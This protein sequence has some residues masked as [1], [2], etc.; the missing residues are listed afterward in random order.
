MQR[1]AAAAAA[2]AY[3]RATVIPGKDDDAVGGHCADVGFLVS[4]QFVVGRW[5]LVAGRLVVAGRS[6]TMISYEEGRKRALDT[7]SIGC[8]WTSLGRGKIYGS[9]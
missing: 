5:S 8:S 9:A 6:P 3:L 2:A 1:S 7:D 4:L